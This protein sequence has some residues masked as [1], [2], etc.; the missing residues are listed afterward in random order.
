K[1]YQV[2]DLTSEHDG[3]PRPMYRMEAAAADAMATPVAPGEISITAHVN[4]R[5]Y[6]ESGSGAPRTRFATAARQSLID[7][8]ET[9]ISLKRGGYANAFRALIVFQQ[10]GENPGEGKRAS[11]QGVRKLRLS[12]SGRP[13]TQLQ[14]VC[15]EGF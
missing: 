4:V 15:L 5:F 9:G 7:T 12:A 6:L 11:V 13:E 2:S 3:G 10:C 14:T 1:A 8:V